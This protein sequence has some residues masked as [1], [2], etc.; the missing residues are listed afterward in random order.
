MRAYETKLISKGIIFKSER[1]S[2]AY[3]HQMVMIWHILLG[4][5]AYDYFGGHLSVGT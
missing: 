3:F 5:I 1:E 2:A 4:E